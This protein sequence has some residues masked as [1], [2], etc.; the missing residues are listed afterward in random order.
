MN[1]KFLYRDKAN[2]YAKQGRFSAGSY[3]AL[4][5]QAYSEIIKKTDYFNNQLANGKWKGIMSMNPR[6]LPAYKLP[7]ANFA[8][9][10]TIPDWQVVPEGYAQADSG[11]RSS[12]ALPE[13]DQWN[14]QS[15]FVDVYL[16]RETSLSFTVSPSANWIKVSQTQGVLSPKEGQSDVRLWVKIDWTKAPKQA[17]AGTISIISRNQIKVIAIKANNAPVSALSD[18]TGFVESAGYI[19]VNADPC[20]TLTFDCGLVDP[21]PDQTPMTP[22]R[23]NDNTLH[24]G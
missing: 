20:I 22:H 23:W 13:F 12:L 18:Y 8:K 16:S 11:A 19:A 14:R 3:A 10:S 9:K 2:L 5:K 7:E 24:F 6:E 1:K 15:Y 21:Y 4:S 17:L